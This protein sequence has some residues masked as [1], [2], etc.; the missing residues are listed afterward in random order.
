LA[1]LEHRHDADWEWTTADLD[2][3]HDR[4]AAWRTAVDAPA[5]PAAAPTL[6][7][8]REGLAN[9]LDS[10]RALTAVDRWAEEV[11]LHRGDDP[12]APATVR[13]AVDALLG[14]LL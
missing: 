8:V 2:R 11:R 14:V 1:L 10:P 9:G 7:R 3:A 4:L 6:A 13:A 12:T 5:G